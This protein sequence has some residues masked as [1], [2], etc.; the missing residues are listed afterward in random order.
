[1]KKYGVLL[2]NLGT[3]DKAEKKFVSAYLREFLMDRN[4]LDIPFLIRFFLVNFIIVPKRLSAVTEL[5]QSIW[6]EDSPIRSILNKQ[7]SALELLLNEDEQFI[8]FVEP[9]MTY[10]KPSIHNALEKLME[11]QVDELITLPLYPQF[12]KTTTVSVRE[13]LENAQ[14]SLD[15]QLKTHFIA[16][17]FEHEAYIS[18]LSEQITERWQSQ[19]HKPDA[20][21]LSYHG[22]PVSYVKRGDPYYDHCQKTTSALKKALSNHSVPVL[23][24]FQSRVTSQEWLRPYTEEKILA[25][26][27][28]GVKSLEVCCPGFSADCLETVDEVGIEYKKLFLDKGGLSYFAYPALNE[29]PAHIKLMASLVNTAINEEL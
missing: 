1:M 11:K 28:E 2:V 26:P 27:D 15:C 9:A 5:Y 23:E 14:H 29:R 21:L 19:N 13:R 3:P 17:Y 18:A 10:G 12:S 20:L 25:F 16:Q 6:Q 8:F 22:I 4:V 7:A 24:S